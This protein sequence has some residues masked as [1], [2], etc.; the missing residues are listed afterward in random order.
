MKLQGGRLGVS[1]CYPVLNAFCKRL[2]ASGK[3]P[4]VALVVCVHMPVDPARCHSQ[5]QESRGQLAS[6]SS[7]SRTV[8]SS[9]RQGRCVSSDVQAVAEVRQARSEAD[10]I[11]IYL[12][13]AVRAC[14]PFR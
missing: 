8:L 6:C 14:G 7:T 11:P 13:Q 1:R 4:K 12:T 10:L 2:I 5:S 3:L 9:T